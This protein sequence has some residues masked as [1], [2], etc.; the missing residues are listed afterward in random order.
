MHTEF[1][2]INYTL[3][4]ILGQRLCTVTVKIWKQFW[5]NLFHCGH[6]SILFIY[7]LSFICSIF[8]CIISPSIHLPFTNLLIGTPVPPKGNANESDSFLVGIFFFYAISFLVYQTSSKTRKRVLKGAE[9]K[10]RRKIKG[11]SVKATFP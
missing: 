2:F 7:Y 1:K 6:Q 10:Q 8:I 11:Y 9:K 4:R 3:W 5:S